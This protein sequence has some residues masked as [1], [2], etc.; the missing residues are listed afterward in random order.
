MA[1]YLKLKK[2][3]HHCCR[4][5]VLN[6]SNISIIIYKKN[7][8]CK[9]KVKNNLII[10]KKMFITKYKYIQRLKL[11]Y[12]VKIHSIFSRNER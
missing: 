4:I 5:I 10:F 3:F 8:L 7:I 11:R 6:I 1:D 9:F 12:F 2:R